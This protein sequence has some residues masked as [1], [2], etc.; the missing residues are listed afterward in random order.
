MLLQ[1]IWLALIQFF[2]FGLELYVM[3]NFRADVMNDTLHTLLLALAQT[4]SWA[5]PMA[6]YVGFLLGTPARKKVV[7][8]LVADMVPEGIRAWVLQKK[9]A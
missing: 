6:I 8:R 3:A 2:T 7:R 1:F 5:L 9:N 4:N